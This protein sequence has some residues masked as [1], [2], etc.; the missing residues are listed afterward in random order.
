MVIFLLKTK[1]W[2]TS[3]RVLLKSDQKLLK[4]LLTFI[5]QKTLNKELNSFIYPN[6]QN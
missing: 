2:K 1:I 4:K 6:S 3:K 5:L